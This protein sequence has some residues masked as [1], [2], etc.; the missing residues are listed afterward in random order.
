M[1]LSTLLITIGVMY[2]VVV[3]GWFSAGM[4][5]IVLAVLAILGGVWM[6]MNGTDPS[7]RWFDMRGSKKR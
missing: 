7:S 1:L 3:M 2:L 5:K 6:M 4:F